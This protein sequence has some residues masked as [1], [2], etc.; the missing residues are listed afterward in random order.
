MY[1]PTYLRAQMRFARALKSRPYAMLWIGQVISNLG[2]GIFYVALPWQVLLMTHSATAMALVLIAMMVP[3]IVF[4]LIGGVVADRL[5]RRLIFL[6]SVSVRG[7]LV[8]LIMILGFLVFL[9]FLQ[10]F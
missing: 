10:S 3:Q 6:W 2:D 1:I 5:P 9:Q 4:T 7:L 8:F